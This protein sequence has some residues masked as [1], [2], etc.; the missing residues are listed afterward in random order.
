MYSRNN[1]SENERVSRSTVARPVSVARRQRHQFLFHMGPVAL[2]I[3]SVLLIALMAV[4]YL[5]QQG[6]AVA[7]NQKLQDM[8]NQQAQLQRQKQDLLDS[9]ARERSPEYITEHAKELGLVPAD[10][11]HIRVIKVQ[12]LQPVATSD[13]DNQP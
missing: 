6:Q 3:T 11:K 7:A 2:S 5:S 4:L 13:Q 1:Q 12:N 10:P 9:I 8:R